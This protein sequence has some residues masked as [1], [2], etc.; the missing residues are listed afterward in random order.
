MN[1]PMIQ[2]IPQYMCVDEDEMMGFPVRYP[3]IYY[4]VFPRIRS[5]CEEMDV[6]SNPCMYPYPSEE[7]ISSMTDRILEEVVENDLSGLDYEIRVGR[8]QFVFGGRRVLRDL[9][10]ILLIRELLRRRR[11]PPFFPFGAFGGFGRPNYG[12]GLYY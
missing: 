6:P 1:C 10:S 12:E 2:N 7:T 3:Q 11:R 5:I 4:R 9:I 8:R